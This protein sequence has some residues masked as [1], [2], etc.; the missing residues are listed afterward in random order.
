MEAATGP[1]VITNPMRAS[2]IQKLA[3]Y[4][5]LGD[6]AEGDYSVD[7]IKGLSEEKARRILHFANCFKDPQ[8]GW[9]IA[10]TL[11][12]TDTPF[13]AIL[14]GD[15]LCIWR[16]YKYI[17]GEED[18]AIS[19]AVALTL[20]L[21]KNTRSKIEALLVADGVDCAFVASRLNIPKDVVTAYEKLFFNVLDRKADH[22]YISDIVYPEGRM[23]EAME[24]YLE[25]VDLSTLLLRA[26]YTKG[27]KHV[28]YAAALTKDNPYA[29]RDA[30]SGA[31]ELDSIFMAEGCLY[32][33]M[34]WLHQRRNAMPIM[35]ARL[36][37]QASKMGNNDGQ[38][39]ASGLSAI[40]DNLRG[41]LLD[42]TNIKLEARA[43]A[44]EAEYELTIPSNGRETQA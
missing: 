16:A 24:D 39:T 8:F 32:A 29:H 20:D 15:D 38:A 10:Q 26:G 11:A 35:N 40:S 21:N 5:P 36:S 7:G 42:I 18:K 23:V 22:A 37:M 14:T 6:P 34:G 41:E 19:H 44:M 9:K 4:I 13:P 28:L 1:G 3:W 2:T 31:A 25:N 12:E 33:D 30:V 17:K 43:R 27:I